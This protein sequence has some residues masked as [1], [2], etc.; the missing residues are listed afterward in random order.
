MFAV[1]AYFVHEI[2]PLKKAVATAV[3]KDIPQNG[4]VYQ[5]DTALQKR[6]W[7]KLDKLPPV[8]LVVGRHIF[9]A[10]LIQGLQYRFKL[11]AVSSSKSAI[12]RSRLCMVCMVDS[13]WATV[14]TLYV[15][16]SAHQY[17]GM[18][19]SKKSTQ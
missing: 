19:T 4:I 10:I 18:V 8:F 11:N 15:S 5:P 6:L 3:D 16:A 13:L 2:M 12:V 14:P 17:R 9:A 7:Q 1:G